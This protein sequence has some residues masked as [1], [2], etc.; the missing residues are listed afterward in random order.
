MTWTTVV[1]G[2][3]CGTGGLRGP[4][5]N[6]NNRNISYNNNSSAVQESLGILLL[7]KASLDM[8]GLLPSWLHQPEQQLR[9]RSRKARRPS[10]RHRATL[11]GILGTRVAHAMISARSGACD[12][13]GR[14]VCSDAVRADYY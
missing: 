14:T 2:R 11:H 8:A 6:I 5:K 10:R 9:N 13:D 1:F 4:I 7:F 12:R 3:Y